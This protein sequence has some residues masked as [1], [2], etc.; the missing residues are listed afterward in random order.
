MMIYEVDNSNFNLYKHS[1][2]FYFVY[3]NLK[4]YKLWWIW[5]RRKC[6]IS[7]NNW[8]LLHR[9]EDLIWGYFWLQWQDRL[10]WCAGY[11]L[12]DDEEGFL[13]SL[14][15]LLRMIQSQSFF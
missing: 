6:K 14:T 7:I 12:L 10:D 5:W 4:V 11:N 13:L 2:S 3:T 1:S 9:D 8:K 15:S